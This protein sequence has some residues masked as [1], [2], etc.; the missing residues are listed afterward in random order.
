MDKLLL[1]DL[2]GTVREP[3]SDNKFIQYPTDQRAIAG[4][5]EALIYY[6][7]RGWTILGI[8]N[9]GSVAAGYKSLE[10]AIDEQRY[11]LDLLPQITAIYFCPDFEGQQCWLVKDGIEAKPV[12]EAIHP[13]V[14]VGSFRNLVGNFRKPQPGMLQAA[15]KIHSDE[16]AEVWFVG[17]RPEDQQ[18]AA[19]ANINYLDA[20]LWRQRFLPGMHNFGRV[21]HEQ[22]RFLEGA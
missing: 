11:T 14:L 3:I 22:L 5:K 19:A 7:L 12:H 13:S 15:I 21:T 20:A 8:T 17:D 16:G 9:Q 1:V 2:D 10:D 18:A 4:V 6:C